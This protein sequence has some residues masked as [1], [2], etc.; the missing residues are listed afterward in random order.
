MRAYQRFLCQVLKR[1]EHEP[2][3][4]FAEIGVKRGSTS[5]T[6]LAESPR[7][8]A[9]LVD[10]WAQY[11]PSHPAHAEFGDKLIPQTHWDTW[12]AEAMERMK[13]YRQR[14]QVLRL[15]SDAAVAQVEEL[16]L[17]LIF[18]DSDH[19]QCGHEFR[20]W[21]PKLQR[22]GS[23]VFHDKTHQRNRMGRWD[24]TESLENFAKFYGH[25][26]LGQFGC[27]RFDKTDASPQVIDRYLSG[28]LAG[29]PVRHPEP[30]GARLWQKRPK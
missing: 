9:L 11:S 7:V 8:H 15:D 12:H 16:S 30:A 22:G 29:Q 26:D 18:L 21:W 19:W 23:M 1:F 2:Q 13:P 5:Q 25:T 20:L 24:V 10:P 3:V 14:V 27:G 4:R 17:H 6:I 28:P